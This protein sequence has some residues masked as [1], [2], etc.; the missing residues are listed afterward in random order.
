MTRARGTETVESSHAVVDRPS[1][2]RLRAFG[3]YEDDGTAS[4]VK[5]RDFKDATDLVVPPA[6]VYAA[7]N[8]IG[9][10]PELSP[11]VTASNRQPP[12]ALVYRKS[13]RAQSSDD[14]ET[15]VDDG[16][17]NTLNTFDTGDARTTHA[18]LGAYGVRRLTEVECERLQG[19]PDGWTEP[20]GSAS[21]R[22]KAMGNAVTVNTVEWILRRLVAADREVDG[23]QG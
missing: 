9:M 22:Y 3:D 17:A 15:W 19:F 20:A 18:A 1:G 14:A 7:G 10:S 21:A 12:S 16:I 11:T 23:G 13:R 4:T 8:E 2:F 5:A 6:G